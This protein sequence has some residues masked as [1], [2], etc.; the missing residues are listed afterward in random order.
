MSQFRQ[1]KGTKNGIVKTIYVYD[2]NPVYD[3]AYKSHNK[4]TLETCR[5][6]QDQT[7]NEVNK[8]IIYN[9]FEKEQLRIKAIG[10]QSFLDFFKQLADSKRGQI[11]QLDF[12]V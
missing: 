2:Q 5:N 10:E 4:E 3:E 11:Q 1:R 12:F 8:D 7:R 9:D 6:N